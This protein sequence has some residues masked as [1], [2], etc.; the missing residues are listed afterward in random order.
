MRPLSV[1]SNPQIGDGVA[2]T[3]TGTG[4]TGAFTVNV[5]GLTPDTVYSFAAYATNSQGVSYSVTGFFVT[6]ANPSSWQQTWF[7]DPASASAALNADPYHTGVQNIQVLRLS[8]AVSGSQH[9]Q[10]RPNSR[11]CRWAAAIFSTASPNLAG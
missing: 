5:S 6:L 11:R 7:G 10:L 2:T 1:D 3:A 9:G 4:T 8:R